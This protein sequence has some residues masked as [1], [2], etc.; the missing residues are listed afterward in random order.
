MPSYAANE[1]KELIHIH[2]VD[3]KKIVEMLPN[4]SD[5]KEAQ[6]L[7]TKELN[8]RLEHDVQKLQEQLETQKQKFIEVCLLVF[9]LSSE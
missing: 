1:I 4:L 3:A 8:K 7:L 2:G 5:D 9:W 6:I